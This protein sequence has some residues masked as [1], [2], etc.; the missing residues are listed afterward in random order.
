MK[1]RIDQL[2][3]QK[4]KNIVSIFIT[5]GFPEKY[6][7]LKIIS[8]LE[9]ANADMI[10][11]GIPFSDPLADGET[12]QQSNT[13]A[14]KNGMTLVTLFEQL[15][16]VRG[17]TQK[18]LLLMG[19]L[20]SV[21]QFGITEFYNKCSECGI[22]GVI[23]PDLPLEEFEGEHEEIA[24]RNGIH[25][26]FLISPKTSLERIKYIDSKTKGFLYL[27]SSNSTTGNKAVGFDELKEKMEAMED[28]NLKNPI[29]IGF[30][31]KNADTFNQASEL[32]NGAI[33]GSEYIRRIAHSNNFNTTTQDFINELTSSN[34][35]YS[36]TK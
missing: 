25:H 22:D 13:I 2:F 17:L 21:I 10:E 35:D 1:N 30:G 9:L 6:D 32:C 31:I 5:A 18:P 11:I 12:I 19:Y 14:L 20:N 28:L 27:V 33:I 36:T 29:L 23:L 4:K 16:T 24:F 7:T 8:A 34:Y 15:K 3:L 26:V